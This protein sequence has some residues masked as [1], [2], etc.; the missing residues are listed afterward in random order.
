MHSVHCLPET[1]LGM[2]E[3]ISMFHASLSVI[4]GILHSTDKKNRINPPSYLRRFTTNFLADDK[5]KMEERMEPRGWAGG[6]TQQ[7]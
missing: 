2:N 1:F 5:T 3:P 4:W 6:G 7:S